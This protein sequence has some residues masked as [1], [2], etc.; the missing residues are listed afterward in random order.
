MTS[1]GWYSSDYD[2]WHTKF[3]GN[4]LMFSRQHRGPGSGGAHLFP[5]R[6]MLGTV[7]RRG[8]D[9]VIRRV[10][11]LPT[12]DPVAPVPNT[13]MMLP[14]WK[15]LPSELSTWIVRM[16]IATYFSERHFSVWLDHGRLNRSLRAWMTRHYAF[17]EV[18]GELGM[19]VQIM[20]EFWDECLTACDS[21]PGVST[22]GY[23]AFEGWIEHVGAE[24]TFFLAP[25]ERLRRPLLFVTR[26]PN[27]PRACDQ[28]GVHT[29][30]VDMYAT[31]MFFRTCYLANS[32]V[33]LDPNVGDVSLGFYKKLA[34]LW[35]LVFPDLCIYCPQEGVASF[36]ELIHL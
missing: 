11:R 29:C 25:D 30:R 35:R 18:G 3:G 24:P 12:D 19:T 36:E 27:G 14:V 23:A 26:L 16:L 8:D 5:P 4:H 22:F 28:V 33:V 21:G 17:D 13:T 32:T 6:T 20:E 2:S 9:L 15:N 7:H 1:P 10:P 34:D 31:H